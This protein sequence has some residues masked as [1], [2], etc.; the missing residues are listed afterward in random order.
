MEA[1]VKLDIV[2]VQEEEKSVSLRSFSYGR[3]KLHSTLGTGVGGQDAD[4]GD[5]SRDI[6]SERLSPYFTAHG[7]WT[8]TSFFTAGESDRI[9]ETRFGRGGGGDSLLGVSTRCLYPCRPLDGYSY[10]YSFRHLPTTRCRDFVL[11]D[12]RTTCSETSPC[13]SRRIPRPLLSSRAVCCLS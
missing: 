4:S 2:A 7:V 1:D 6:D 9:R 13:H 12:R 3:G 8:G 11:Q 5:S 10:R